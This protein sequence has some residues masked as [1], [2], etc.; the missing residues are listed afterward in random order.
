MSLD[1]SKSVRL[2][3]AP[4]A[5]ALVSLAVAA[6]GAAAS[7]TD[8]PPIPDGVTMVG[9]VDLAAILADDALDAL[10]DA[11]PVDDDGPA[12]L[13]D[14]L[15]MVGDRVGFD[16]RGVSEVLFFGTGADTDEIGLILSGSLDLDDI[17]VAAGA[18]QGSAPA[19]ADVAGR[20]VYT[21]TADGEDFSIAALADGR[22]AAGHPDTVRGMVEVAAGQ[23][24]AATGNLLDRLDALGSPWLK[25]VADVSAADAAKV[26]GEDGPAQGFGGTLPIDISA[27]EDVRVVSLTVDRQGDEFLVTADLGFT[28]ADA[29]LRM[30]AMIEGVAS[31]FKAFAPDPA[32]ASVLDGLTVDATGADVA[33]DFSIGTDDAVTLVHSLS[34]IFSEDTQVDIDT[35]DIP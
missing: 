26:F 8:T 5:L 3:L 24:A 23:R 34:T 13:E 12:T 32:M 30:G 33:I 4:P 7:A 16:V 10:F 11:L 27:F 31:L 21:F 14:A 25:V 15:T 2:G 17:L 1:I 9:Q 20:T 28:S 6:C 19:L 22:L 35:L 29:A 18:E